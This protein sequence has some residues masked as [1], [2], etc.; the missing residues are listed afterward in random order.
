MNPNPTRI[1]KGFRK[2]PFFGAAFI[3]AKFQLNF[4]GLGVCRPHRGDV[5]WVL[6]AGTAN[7]L[8][9]NVGEGSAVLKTALWLHPG[10]TTG[11]P[12]EF[13]QLTSC[14]WKIFLLQSSYTRLVTII[15]L[16]A[17]RTMTGTIWVANYCCCFLSDR[18][19][20]GCRIKPQPQDTVLLDYLA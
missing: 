2:G 3:S 12:C 15:H 19:K 16:K 4:G 8:S 14:L 9:C 6:E 13:Q 17:P 20:V 18:S 1:I 7:R 10:F 5:K 11:W